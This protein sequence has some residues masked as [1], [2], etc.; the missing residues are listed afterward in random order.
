MKKLLVTLLTTVL[1]TSMVACGGK[2]DVNNDTTETSGVSTE[3]VT[4]E[5]TETTETESAG[6]TADG[7]TAGQIL[8]DA[9]HKMVEENPLKTTQE[10]ADAL[11]ANEII[12]FMG[13][14]MP[15][16][17]GLLTGFGNA[18]ITGFEEATVFMPMIGVYPFIGYVFELAEDAD[19]EA[20]KATLTE[21]ADM[22][23]N[24]C[25][26]A[27]ETI[28]ESID[29]KVFFIMCKKDLSAE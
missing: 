14:A 9:F 21:N 6:G 24:I 8:L 23:W 1:V 5:S 12:P 7:E 13:G 3:T 22:R 18:E 17:P 4:T 25:V 27:E 20:F 16:E 2:N 28:V 29:E 11:I 19:V 15:V 26:E 10:Y